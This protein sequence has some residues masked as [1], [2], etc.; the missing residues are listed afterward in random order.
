MG[1]ATRFLAYEWIRGG[2]GWEIATP[3][4]NLPGTG[5]FGYLGD[6]AALAA[7]ID[8]VMKESDANEMTLDELARSATDLH[9]LPPT[10]RETLRHELRTLNIRLIADP[11]D[12]E[13]LFRRRQA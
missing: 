10:A 8:A 9:F 1:I 5:G 7:K 11:D 6:P 4:S 2:N 3:T 13:T 12:G